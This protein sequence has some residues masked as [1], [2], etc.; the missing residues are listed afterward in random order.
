[1]Q[2]IAVV[3]AGIIGLSTTLK[4][5]QNG[6]IVELLVLK[7]QSIFNLIFNFASIQIIN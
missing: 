2:K 7:E 5:N 4:L 6:Y 3:G 1:M